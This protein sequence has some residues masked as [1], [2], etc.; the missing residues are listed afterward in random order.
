MTDFH[1]IICLLQQAQFDYYI[2]TKYLFFFCQ[3]KNQS[4]VLLIGL[5]RPLFVNFRTKKGLFPASFMTENLKFSD[6]WI[7]TAV[8]GRDRY[9]ATTTVHIFVLLK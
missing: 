2:K 3:D 6:D 8:V 7:R 5:P 1:I 9:I 4:F